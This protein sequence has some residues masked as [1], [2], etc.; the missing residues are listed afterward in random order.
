MVDMEIPS[1]D[2]QFLR[3]M[4]PRKPRHEIYSALGLAKQGKTL[5]YRDFLHH[6]RHSSDRF[7]IAPGIKGMVMLVFFLP[8]FPYDRHKRCQA[9]PLQKL[10]RKS[11]V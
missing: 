6:L 5:F 2:V 7:R 8:S 9:R 10:K 1:A 4:M 3:S 11:D